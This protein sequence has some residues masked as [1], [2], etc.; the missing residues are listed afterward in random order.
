MFGRSFRIATI[1]GIPVNVD[2][3]WIWIA[4]VAVYS[5]W[6]RFE[7]GFPGLGDGQAIAY[8]LV[9]A[10]LFFGSV[11]LHE[12]AHAVTARL[13]GI[14][15][16]GITLV[17]FG[18]FTAA[19]SEER[20]PGPAFAIALLGPLTSLTLG[21]LFWAASSIDDGGG[22]LSNMFRYVGFINLFM[23]IFNVLPG[24]PLDGGRVLQ[25]VVW[26][27]TRSRATGTRIAAKAG[28][29]VGILLFV[30]AAYE[31]SR[32][33]VISAIWL[34]LI[35]L[36]I[37][38]GARASEQQAGVAD[39]LAAATVA[40]AMDPPPPAV[41]ADMTLSETLDRFLRGREGEVFPVI[42]VGGRVIGVISF[43]SARAIGS[44]DPL[45]PARDAVVPLEHVAVLRPDERLDEAA[46]RL[47]SM[48]SA[49]VLRDGTLVGSL[50]GGAVYR[51][52]RSHA[53]STS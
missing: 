11:F 47:G 52:V 3:S 8:A 37:F 22:P 32:Q 19:R 42:E 29:G 38:Q 51:W 48:N 43:D 28:I 40:D 49:L 26:G 17:F 24:L 2:S 25:A 5:L 15:V 46:S 31:I 41:P 20:G 1:G 23:A 4:F 18:G 30:A 33:N 34:G 45:R 35:G 14:R 7:R 27:V 39:R 44:V 53:R 9:A 13:A 36:F 10:A 6:T 21:G 16:E 12:V 50:S